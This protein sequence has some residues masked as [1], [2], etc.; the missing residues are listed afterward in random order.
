M[1]TENS[2]DQ[3]N[4]DIITWMSSLN[5]YTKQNDFFSRRQEGTGEWLLEADCFKKWVDGTERILWCPGLRMLSIERLWYT[6]FILTRYKRAPVKPSS[7]TTP[8]I[9]LPCVRALTGSDS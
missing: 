4:Q 9:E 1:D 5:F 3:K 7:C 6:C 2:L 8:P